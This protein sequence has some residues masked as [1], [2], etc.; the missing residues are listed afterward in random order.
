VTEKIYEPIDPQDLKDFALLNLQ[1]IPRS[2]AAKIFLIQAVSF[3]LIVDGPIE[4]CIIANCHE[5]ELPS[6]TDPR[7]QW[8]LTEAE[9][10]EMMRVLVEA[11]GKQR[12]P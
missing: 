9:A 6:A 4:A 10:L 12:T 2:K 1:G 8:Y 5:K 11:I 3:A 7:W